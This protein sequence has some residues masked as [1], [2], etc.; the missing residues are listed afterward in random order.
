MFAVCA[1]QRGS[2]WASLLTIALMMAVFAAQDGVM[3]TR[4]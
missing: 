4:L 3:W 1:D 2:H